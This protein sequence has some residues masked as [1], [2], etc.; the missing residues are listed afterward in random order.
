MPQ[1]EDR[2]QL[3]PNAPNNANDAPT[4]AGGGERNKAPK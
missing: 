1:P 3:K 4:L 2:K